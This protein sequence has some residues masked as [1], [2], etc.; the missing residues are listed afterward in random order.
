MRFAICNEHWGNEPFEKVCEDAAACGYQ[1]LE[2]AP[3]S[4]KEDPRELNLADATRLVLGHVLDTLLRLLHPMTPF[5]T[6]VLWTE[7]T[8]GESVVVADGAGN[9]PMPTIAMSDSDA[10]NVRCA[11]RSSIEPRTTTDVPIGTGDATAA[12]R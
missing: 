4:L 10:R 7:L 1:G 3:F 6:E 8:G 5:V 11:K 2:L 9:T 12:S